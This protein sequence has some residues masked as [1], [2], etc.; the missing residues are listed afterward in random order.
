MEVT[1]FSRAEL[2]PMLFEPPNGYRR[3]IHPV[4]GEQLSWSDEILFGWQQFQNWLAGWF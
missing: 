4:P 1:E 2:D 3:V